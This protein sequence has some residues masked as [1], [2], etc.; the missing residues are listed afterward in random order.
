MENLGSQDKASHRANELLDLNCFLRIRSQIVVAEV[1]EL[2]SLAPFNLCH[3]VDDL[4]R[5]ET[6]PREAQFFQRFVRL[7]ELAQIVKVQ[8][9]IQWNLF[10]F[11]LHQLSILP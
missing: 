11:K 6:R 8:G 3:D 2:D 5:E 9:I 1:K 7:Q 4:L 10:D